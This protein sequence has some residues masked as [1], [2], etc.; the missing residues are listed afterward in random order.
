MKIT[1]LPQRRDER[2][3]LHRAGDVLTINGEEFDFAPLPEGATLPAE[4]IDSDWITGPVERIEGALHMTLILPHGP[5][6]AE[7]TR[8]PAALFVN[9]NGPVAVPLWSEPKEEHDNEQD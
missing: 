3:E 7:A 5:R 1:F 2:L 6:A 8:F 9:G 4:A